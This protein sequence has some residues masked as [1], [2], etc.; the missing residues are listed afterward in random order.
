MLFQIVADFILFLHLFFIVFVVL[1]ALLLFRWPRMVWIHLPAAVWGAV[2]ELGGYIC[3]LTPLENKMRTLAG[4]GAYGGGFIERYLVPVI[5]P[6]G[7]TSSIQLV[8]GLFVIVVNLIIYALLLIRF[9]KNLMKR[10][11]KQ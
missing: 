5:Y 2:V 9:K 6:E 4:Q 3:P 8:L 10:K 7:L 11:E 1:G